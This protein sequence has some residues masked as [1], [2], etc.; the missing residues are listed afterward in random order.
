MSS[1]AGFSPGEA[2]SNSSIGDHVRLTLE[3]ISMKAP[4]PEG[5]QATL[6]VTIED[7]PKGRRKA[8]AGN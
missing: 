2:A 6:D 7:K 4:E 8:N 1:T 5:K 3:E